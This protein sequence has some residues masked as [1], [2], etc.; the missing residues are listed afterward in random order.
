MNDDFVLTC[1]T[2][3]SV[4]MLS[5]KKEKVMPS[6]TNFRI[7][8]TDGETYVDTVLEDGRECRIYAEFDK[9]EYQLYIDGMPENDVFEEIMY[10]G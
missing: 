6:G 3:L 10:A 1:K 5:D 9:N 2:E 8:R 7:I 4:E